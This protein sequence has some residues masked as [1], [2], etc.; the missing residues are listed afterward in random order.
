MRSLIPLCLLLSFAILPAA[1]LQV[2]TLAD[3]R[4]IHARVEPDPK[5]DERYA[6]LGIQF[7]GKPMGGLRV[8]KDDILST[9]DLTED[10]LE[11]HAPK[12]E[13]QRERTEAIS[14]RRLE[15]LSEAIAATQTEITEAQDK[16]KALRDE[17]ETL[18]L[19]LVTRWAEQQDWSEITVEADANQ[20]VGLNQ[21]LLEIRTHLASGEAGAAK[22]EQLC[23]RLVGNGNWADILKRARRTALVLPEGLR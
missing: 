14:D 8:R 16:L 6:Q 22:I 4:E 17:R 3:G 18:R 23:R 21:L 2:V 1:E 20:L 12:V 7:K 9:R 10:E 11:Q 15:Q 5:G 13:T 19:A